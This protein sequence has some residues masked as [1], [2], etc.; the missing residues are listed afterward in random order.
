MLQTII[1]VGTIA[2]IFLG[3]DALKSAYNVY[4]TDFEMMAR[5]VAAVPA[6]ER[7]VVL[8]IAKMAALDTIGQESAFWKQMVKGITHGCAVVE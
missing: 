8:R 1:P 5:A 2:N 6:V 7:A 4:S 3:N